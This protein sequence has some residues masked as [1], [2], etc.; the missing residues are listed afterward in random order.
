MA[1]IALERKDNARAIAELQ[2]LLKVDFNNIAAARQLVG[3]LKEQKVTDAAVLQPAYER[4]ASIDPFDAE[5]HAV[6]GRLA[7]QRR[8]H[9][10]ASREFR[11]VLALKPVDQAAAHAD[12][13]ESYLRGGNQAEARRQTLAALEIAPSYQRA[14]D[15]LLELAGKRP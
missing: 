7:M 15:L 12:L 14:Q 3:L 2:A 10:A 9:D 8:D 5:A 13:A 6:L 4:I 1:E 11:T